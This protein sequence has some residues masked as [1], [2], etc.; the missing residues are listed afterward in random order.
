MNEHTLKELCDALSTLRADITIALPW[1]AMYRWFG[2]APLDLTHY[3]QINRQWAL[4]W[5]QSGER[6]PVPE[7]HLYH[8]ADKL[9]LVRETTPND[10]PAI[11]LTTLG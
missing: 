2:T 11:D 3:E 4:I 8:G 9:T 6:S 10:P 1:D 7:V 5:H